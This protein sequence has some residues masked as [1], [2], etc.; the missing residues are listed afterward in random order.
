MFDQSIIIPQFFSFEKLIIK[1]VNLYCSMVISEKK[2]NSKNSHLMLGDYYF[3]CRT[4]I[5]YCKLTEL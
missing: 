3:Q 1:N 2:K 5:Q 4:L